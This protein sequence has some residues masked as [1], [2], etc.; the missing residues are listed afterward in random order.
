V[1]RSRRS[2]LLLALSLVGLVFCS[3]SAK[4]TGA[5]HDASASDDA[6]DAG[7]SGSS[8]DTGASDATG[9]ADVVFSDIHEL[10]PI[11]SGYHGP[12]CKTSADCT[13]GDICCTD[14]GSLLAHAA[15]TPGPTCEN[16]AEACDGTTGT[17]C[18][19]GACVL[20][21]CTFDATHLTSSVYS[22]SLPSVVG[23]S[24]DEAIDAGN[25]MPTGVDG[26]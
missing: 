22:C 4:S 10:P 14:V 16:G 15:C 5:S 1:S 26:G 6:G 2:P 25:T 3:S 21:E 12:E 23:G 8:R 13:G 20:Y 9:F 24:C 18:A 11:D 19:K 7:K 17:G